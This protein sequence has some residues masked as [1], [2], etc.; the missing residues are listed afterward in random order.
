[1]SYVRTFVG[2]TILFVAIFGVG[3][4]FLLRGCL[5]KYD[6]R[7]AKL[8][9]LYF[10]K[11]TTKILFSLVSYGKTTSYSSGGGFTRKSLSTTYYVQK[12]DAN[13]GEKLM[14]KEVK[15]H[16]EIKNYPIETIGSSGNAAWIFLGE[17]MAFNPYTL[18]QIAD[19]KTLEKNNPVLIGKFPAERQYYKFDIATK[20][21]S[22]TATDGSKWLLNSTTLKAAQ[23]IEEDEETLVKR[24]TKRLEQMYLQ[25][26]KR[27]DSLN[28]RYLVEPGKQY[29]AGQITMSAMQAAHKMYYKKRDELDKYRDSIQELQSNVHL[30]RSEQSKQK[31][32]LSNLS[33]IDGGFSQMA[34][35][36]DTVNGNWYGLFAEDELEKISDRF[37]Y[38]RAYDETARRGLFRSTYAT[39]RYKNANIQKE[40]ATTLTK[41]TFF[42]QGGFLLDKSTAKPFKPGGGN[43]FIIVYKD[44][45]GNDGLIQMARLSPDGTTKWTMNSNLKSWGDWST[46]ESKIFIFG[47]DDP[48]FSSGQYNVLL[49]VDLETGKI[50]RYD[51]SKDR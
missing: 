33:R 13:T 14:E 30:K 15:D 10:Q 1:M 19:I 24:E 50:A 31:S 21:I 42:L 2:G 12:N 39:D 6:E 32:A 41:N 37:D 20:N 3:F 47:K 51:Y 17:L 40:Q 22:F 46:T 9:V 4:F 45:I 11:D 23:N 27:I 43:D 26:N 8:P 36:Q 44:R 18:E 5:S 38:Q 7:S 48:E 16:D 28:K 29:Q 35:N 49:I 34:I 25:V